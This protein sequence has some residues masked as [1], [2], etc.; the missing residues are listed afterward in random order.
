MFFNIKPLFPNFVQLKEHTRNKMKMQKMKKITILSLLLMTGLCAF[1]Q[2]VTDA[3]KLIRYERYE[4]AIDMLKPLSA[5]SDEAKYYMGLAQLGTGDTAAAKATMN[6]I[7]DDDYGRAGRASIAFLEGNTS[8]GM[9][10]LNSLTKRVKRKNWLEYKLAGDATFLSDN[11]DVLKSGVEWYNQALLVNADPNVYVALG[12][13][14]RKIPDA[15]GKAMT[16]Y[17][18]ATRLDPQNSLSYS[19][20]GKLWYDAHVYDSVLVLY[21][22]A[23]E[24]DAENPLPYKYLADAYQYRGSYDLAKQNIE[25]FLERSDKTEADRKKYLNILFLS[26]DYDRVITVGESLL[27]SD[28]ERPYMYRIIGESYLK[29]DDYDNAQ[30][31][32]DQFF[33]K[34]DQKDILYIDYVDMAEINLGKGDTAKADEYYHKA[35]ELMAP[36]SNQATVMTNAADLYKE[37]KDYERAAYW[38]NKALPVSKGEKSDYFWAGYT[39]YYIGKYDEAINTLVT[40]QEKYPD[41]PLGFYW[42]GRA[43][44]KLD[45]EADKGT[46]NKS[47]ERFLEITEGDESQDR[48]RKNALIYLASVAYNTDDKAQARSYAQQI[49]ELDPTDDFA[50]K[51]IANIK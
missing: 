39:N 26:K 46:A 11:Q 9:D 25:G 22:R 37:A 17:Q 14:Y 15:A 1:A 24:Y 31:Y 2:S 8:E 6:G 34:T 21:N 27:G 5:G 28:V 30:K 49:L 4:S 33:Q 3:R 20:Q 40:M 42:G 45:L 32:F 29:K 48:E 36:D 38:Y 23:K 51:M 50:T 12:D 43:Q 13:L 35:L 44:Q 19:Q 7:A 47:Y 18:T 41:E 16:S 10:N